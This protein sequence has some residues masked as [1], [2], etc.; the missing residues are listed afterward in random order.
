MTDITRV[1]YVSAEEYKEK[2][3]RFQAPLRSNELIYVLSGE[4]LV[5]FNGT[6]MHCRG[7]D[8]RFLPKGKTDIYTVERIV[9]GDCIDVFLTQPNRLRKKHFCFIQPI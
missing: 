9:H 4:N 6:H 1:I 2:S 3:T 5:N 7:G 8:I